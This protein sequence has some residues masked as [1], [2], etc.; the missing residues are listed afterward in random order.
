MGKTI[1]ANAFS[2]GMLPAGGHILEVEETSAEKIRSALGGYAPDL[3]IV[4]HAS[5]AQ[6]F[7]TLLG[8]PIAENRVAYVL[9][10]GDIL[11]VGSFP[12]GFRLEEGKVYSREELEKLQ[13][14]WRTI[15]LSWRFPAK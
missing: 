10:P 15:Q 2:L 4:G 13:F 3:S 14:T 9:Q 1:V 7:S 8:A 12:T 11:V 5:T 6:V